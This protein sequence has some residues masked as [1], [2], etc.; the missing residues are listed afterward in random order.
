MRASFHT[1]TTFLNKCKTDAPTWL[2]IDT[3]PKQK[4]EL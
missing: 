3:K 4:K 1:K 2:G